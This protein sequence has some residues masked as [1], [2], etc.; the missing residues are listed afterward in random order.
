MSN[1]TLG[2]V[3]GRAASP[4]LLLTFGVL[5]ASAAPLLLAPVRARFLGPEGRGQFAVF[6]ADLVVCAAVGMLGTRLA[7]YSLKLDGRPRRDTSLWPL[8]LTA[9]LL[10]LSLTLPLA[11]L[12]HTSAG[13]L[14]AWALVASTVFVPGWIVSQL[15]LAR[16]QVDGSKRWIF[17]S[18]GAPPLVDFVLNVAAVAL[19]AMTLASTIV[20][21]LIAELVRTV[22]AAWR[23]AA[24][25]R[26]EV[27]EGG[28]GPSR[29]RE[30]G[31]ALTL[32]AV[33][34]AP[35]AALPLVVTSL[36]V[37]ILS[38]LVPSERIG[39]YAVAKLGLLLFMP[40]ASALEGRLLGHAVRLGVGRG[41]TRASMEVLPLAV[42]VGTVGALLIKPLFGTSFGDA[43]IPFVVACLAGVCRIA[44]DCGSMLAARN[45][46][47]G[48]LVV[49][50][51]TMLSAEALAFVGS[52]ALAPRSVT[53]MTGCLLFTHLVGSAVIYL[54][55]RKDVKLA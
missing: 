8:T 14:V 23:Y 44:F 46:R 15:E 35:A 52:G 36:D 3:R 4:D 51:T 16:A 38:F 45:G 10:H 28:R 41:M 55:M 9:L 34:L 48:A 26:H 13:P 27:P 24:R 31:V 30:E 49:A 40:V 42:V 53:A 6:Q 2:R 12:A 17:G 21:T 19:R 7:S 32:E 20:I 5:A 18:T 54:L 1:E 22:S 39:V 50:V 33:R 11:W 29:A 47:S 43:A 37:I 25:R